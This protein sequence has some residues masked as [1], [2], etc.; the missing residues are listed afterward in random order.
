MVESLNTH[1]IKLVLI[2]VLGTVMLNAHKTLSS[3]M[4]KLMFLDGT[5]L[6]VILTLEKVN[7]DLAVLRWISGKPTLSQALSLLILAFTMASGDARTK[8]TVEILTDSVEFA[9]K[10][11]AI[12]MPT[13]LVL[14]ISSD[15]A[16]N[17]KLIPQSQ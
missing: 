8:M 16:L 4:D 15:Q 1:K 10:M 6:Q 13:E 12:S 5:H 2:T 9:I 7:G 14:Q 3:F 17:L 11:V